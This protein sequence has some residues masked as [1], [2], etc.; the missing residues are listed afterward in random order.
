[1]KTYLSEI[2][3]KINQFSKRLDYL[4][5]I[6]N[7][8]WIVLDELNKSKTVYIFRNNNEL[9]ISNNGKIEKAKWEYLGNNSLLI[10]QKNESF[11]FKHGFLDENILALKLDGK[12]EYAFL[13]NENSFEKELNSIEK[14]N[15]FLNEKYIKIKTVKQKEQIKIDFFHRKLKTNK[16]ILIIKTQQMSDFTNG[17]EVFFNE[18][19]AEDGK[20][21]YGWPSWLMKIKV[22]N[23]KIL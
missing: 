22:K 19:L 18:K 8:H 20:Y 7:Q 17:D 10:D 23:G 12:N 5:L 6:T 3:P 1:M 14:I 2:I 13:V 16:G 9:L 4:T 21:I 11:L 15:Q